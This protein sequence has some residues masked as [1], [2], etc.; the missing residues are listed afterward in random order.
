MWRKASYAGAVLSLS[1]GI[2]ASFHLATTSALFTAQATNPSNTFQAGTL[3]I[4]NS[5]D[6]SAVFSASSGLDGPV[7]PATTVRLASGTMAFGGLG[8]SPDASGAVPYVIGAIGTE[9]PLSGLGG[10]APG[11]I[12]VNSLTIGNVGTL[13][14]GSVVLSVPSVTLANWPAA[15]CD[16]S[17]ALIVGGED[18]CGRGRLT[19]VLRVTAWYAVDATRVVCVLGSN[20]GGMVQASSDAQ[21][22]LGCAGPDYLGD[23]L[24]M[25][26]LS[27]SLPLAE[28]GAAD[29]T[30]LQVTG[31][32]T[33]GPRVVPT[34]AQ[35]IPVKNYRDGALV[36]DW[37]PGR[38]RAITFAV[39]FDP[40]ADN[41]YAGAQASVDLRWNSVSLSGAPS[42]TPSATVGTVTGTYG[43]VTSTTNVNSLANRS[44]SSR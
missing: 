14:A 2:G 18:V 29:G 25:A 3:R 35:G 34:Y 12:L 15:S 31:I 26:D 40:S 17:S 41:R 11:T 30:R 27:P 13:S 32:P 37:E 39:A 23:R 42:S 6:G 33:A 5:R 38:T 24:T 1:L 44:A 10:A 20:R 19:D 28:I 8:A 4:S 16:A 43:V 9:Q 21:A 22:Y 36:L 7:T